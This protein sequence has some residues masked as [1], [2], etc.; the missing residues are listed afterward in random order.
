MT[1][2]DPQPARVNS[3]HGLWLALILNEQETLA[4]LLERHEVDETWIVEV[5]GLQVPH[6]MWSRTRVKHGQIIECRRAAPDEQR[7]E[8][9]ARKQDRKSVV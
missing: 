1:T 2:T 3:H 7:C 6:L 9:C 4:T 8:N 5:G